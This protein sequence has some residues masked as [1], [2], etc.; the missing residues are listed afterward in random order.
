MTRLSYK[1]NTVGSHKIA[2]EKQT[3]K[4]QGLAPTLRNKDLFVW[5][6]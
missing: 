6:E 4:Q 2:D 5:N 3:N 1:E